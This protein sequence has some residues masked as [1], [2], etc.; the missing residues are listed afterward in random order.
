MN[1]VERLKK[2]KSYYCELKHPHWTVEQWHKKID[3]IFI[4]KNSALQKFSV[5]EAIIRNLEFCYTA[6]TKRI[7]CL[8]DMALY[9][10]EKE[11]KENFNKI[12]EDSERERLILFKRRVKE[13]LDWYN[14][15]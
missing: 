7:R 2:L 9:S 12:I 13:S 4:E 8:M 11:K 15:L 6:P 5:E 1:N 10:T 3:N 14:S